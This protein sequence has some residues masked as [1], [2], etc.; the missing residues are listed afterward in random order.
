MDE[1]RNALTE[2]G[3]AV[4]AG[5]V[6]VR[7]TEDETLEEERGT[8]L[9]E[10]GRVLIEERWVVRGVGRITRGAERRTGAV[11]AGAVRTGATLGTLR[12]LTGAADRRDGVYRGVLAGL[13]LLTG[14]ALLFSSVLSATLLPTRENAEAIIPVRLMREAIP[15]R[16]MKKA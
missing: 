11:R 2:R 16:V 13:L 5:R 9:E 7:R 3:D 1:G 15:T 8:L 14:E 10:R 12:R 4:A 6:G